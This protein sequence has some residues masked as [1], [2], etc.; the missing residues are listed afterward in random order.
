M[1][2]EGFD[3]SRLTWGPEGGGGCWRILPMSLSMSPTRGYV[4]RLE[5]KGGW[6]HG[7][8]VLMSQTASKG[9]YIT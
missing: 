3:V 5:T 4:C 2:N 7:I 9:F 6:I 1:I 8:V